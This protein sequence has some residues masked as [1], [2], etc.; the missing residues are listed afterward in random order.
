MR[1][2]EERKG[3]EEKA[4]GLDQGKS[5][6]KKVGKVRGSTRSLIDNVK[7]ERWRTMDETKDLLFSPSQSR[8]TRRIRRNTT[9]IVIHLLLLQ[10]ESAIRSTGCS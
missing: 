7:P 3:K 10:L 9:T 8:R 5:S 6:H 1:A 4:N 2:P